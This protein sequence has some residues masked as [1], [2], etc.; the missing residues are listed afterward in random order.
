M[1]KR[2]RAGAMGS[3]LGASI[4]ALCNQHLLGL[5]ERVAL[6]Y[7]LS[8]DELKLKYL[9]LAADS[10]PVAK[11]KPVKKKKEAL[12]PRVACSAQVKGQPCKHK[13]QPG[14]TLCHL[15][16]RSKAPKAPKVCCTGTTSKGQPC[17][18]RAQPGENLCHLHLGRARRSDPPLPVSVPVPVPVPVICESAPPVFCEPCAEPE[19]VEVE[20]TDMSALELEERLKRIVAPE[21]TVI[22]ADD[23]AARLKAIETVPTPVEFRPTRAVIEAHGFDDEP[24]EFD[25]SQMESPTSQRVLESMQAMMKASGSGSGSITE[26]D[27]DGYLTE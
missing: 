14:Q 11:P 8:A 21:E 2:A 18:V 24:E 20:S 19:E 1:V 23:L 5:L 3:T 26:E 6:D 10:I 27:E 4:S 13:A 9:D 22:S 17:S 25:E 15:H 12:E 16:N 7:G